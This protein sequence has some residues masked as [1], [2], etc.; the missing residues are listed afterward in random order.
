MSVLTLTP[1][2]LEL[3]MVVL[4]LEVVSLAVP[5]PAFIDIKIDCLVNPTI[6][7]DAFYNSIVFR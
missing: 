2:Y 1:P 4:I 3:E 7:D 5:E 6:A